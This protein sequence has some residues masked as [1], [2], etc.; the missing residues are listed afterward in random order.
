MHMP[1]PLRV[2]PQNP[3]L[4]EFRGQPRV[5][6]TATEHY[7]AVMN[8]PFHFER[9]LADAAEKGMTLTRLFMLFRELQTAINPYSTCKPESPD[10]IAPF[11]RTGPGRAQDG[12]LKYDLDRPNPEFFDRLQRFMTLASD[13]GLIV[14]VVLLSNTYAPEVW[15]LNPLNARNNIN[16]LED[17]E[18]PDYLSQRHPRLFERQAAH[19]RRIV[20]A[21]NSF[22]NVLLEICNEPGGGAKGNPINP[23]PAEVNRWL[24]AL[25]NVVRKTEAHLPVQHLIVGQEAFT[26]LPSQHTSELAFRSMNY[27]G[28]N[29]HPLPNLTFNG[30]SYG[31]GDFMSKQLALRPLRDFGLATYAESK[32]L[33]QDEDNIASEYKDFEAWTIHRKRAW[34][35]LL[36][37]GHYDYIDFSIVNGFETGTP[38]SQAAIRNWFKILSE[39]IHSLDLV[40]ARPLPGLV[41]AAPPHTLD[42]AFGI[43]GE[44]IVIYLADEREFASARGLPDGDNL[45]RGA[46]QPISGQ[47]NLTLPPG[48]YQLRFF[49]S[50]TGAYTRADPLNG[51][52]TPVTIAM[53]TF[54]HDLVIRITR[55]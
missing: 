25:I 31:L 46:G 26:Y 20:E 29:M 3:K 21:V 11:A 35:V 52:P 54:I 42:V 9:Y 1:Q 17:I 2:H 49:D 43:A 53:P 12:E 16:G 41:E 32:P 40:H 6:L 7:G 36:T 27:D 39:F 30:R 14:E 18:W 38:A 23:S 19:V 13:Y 15:A 37:G 47:T 34:T 33:N 45:D 24:S 22:D 55:D 4:F 48:K 8:R 51:G 28:V 5:L 50:Q 44:D 10:Y